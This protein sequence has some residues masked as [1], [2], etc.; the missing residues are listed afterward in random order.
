MKVPFQA[1]AQV[2]GIQAMGAAGEG[3]RFLLLSKK[4]N[5]H[6]KIHG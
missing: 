3:E 1:V 4:G 5:K 6:E 2:T